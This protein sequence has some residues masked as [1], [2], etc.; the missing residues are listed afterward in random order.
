MVHRTLMTV[1]C[2]LFCTVAVAQNRPPDIRI[3]GRLPMQL[4]ITYGP[5]VADGLVSVFGRADGVPGAMYVSVHADRLNP[6][7]PQLGSGYSYNNAYDY[8]GTIQLT[9]P[10]MRGEYFRIL[11]NGNTQ[12]GGAQFIGNFQAYFTPINR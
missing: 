10:V 5:A 2:S 12:C 3:G 6:P 9:V 11:C 8:L 1:V 4:G 7:V